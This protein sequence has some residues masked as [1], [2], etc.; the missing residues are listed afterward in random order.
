MLVLPPNPPIPPAM[1]RTRALEAAPLALACLWGQ[2]ELP[3]G[4]RAETFHVSSATG[5]DAVRN[6]CP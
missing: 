6:D 5:D 3:S 1:T 4:P 2:P